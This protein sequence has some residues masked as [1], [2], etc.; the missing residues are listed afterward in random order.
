MRP[1]MPSVG[2][3]IRPFLS[4]KSAAAG[5]CRLHGAHQKTE[6]LDVVSRP[7]RSS[8]G[9]IES[10]ATDAEDAQQIVEEIAAAPV[11]AVERRKA[12]WS[13]AALID[14]KIPEISLVITRFC[15]ETNSLTVIECG[16]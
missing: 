10:D 14:P 3:R 2:G 5:V 16:L 11:A 1:T 13:S 7:I 9:R 8:S 4:R 6:P 15:L 12:R